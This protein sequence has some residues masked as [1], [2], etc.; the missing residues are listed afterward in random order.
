LVK[1]FNDEGN[2][3]V[4]EGGNKNW[5]SSLKNKI[6]ELNIELSLAQ[7]ACNLTRADAARLF[8]TPN[9]DDSCY[10]KP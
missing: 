9:S 1:Q 6:E 5:N 4:A 7:V 8:Q 3:A 10:Q 2:K